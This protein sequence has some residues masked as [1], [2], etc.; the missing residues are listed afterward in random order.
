MCAFVYVLRAHRSSNL[1]SRAAT[2]QQINHENHEC[3]H[4]QQMNQTSGYVKTDS[5]QPEN[6]KNRYN[7]PKLIALALPPKKYA[8]Q[9]LHFTNGH[10]ATLLAT[11]PTANPMGC[12]ARCDI[13]CT[14]VEMLTLQFFVKC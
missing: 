7:P 13:Y 9:S 12:V 8:A 4:Q 2:A 10:Q 14:S 6:Q 3:N 1:S 11:V 5:Q